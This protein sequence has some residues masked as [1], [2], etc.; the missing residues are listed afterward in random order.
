MKEEAPKELKIL[1]ED[2]PELDEKFGVQ[3]SNQKY[4]FIF[5]VDRSGSMNG[6]SIMTTVEAL[7]LFI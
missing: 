2:K 4:F 6:E 1:E 7:K 5:I 3:K